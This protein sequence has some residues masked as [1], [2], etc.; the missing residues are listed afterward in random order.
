MDIAPPFNPE[1]LRNAKGW[2]SERIENGRYREVSDQPALAA[3]FNLNDAY[4]TS[5]SFRKLC[6]EIDR[7]VDVIMEPAPLEAGT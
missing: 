4:A 5:S 3:V 7:L 2:L 1:A 6:R